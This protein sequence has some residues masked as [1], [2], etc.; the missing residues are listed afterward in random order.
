M[1]LEPGQV[2]KAKVTATPNF[3]LFMAYHG[4]QILVLIPEVSWTASFASC[5]EVAE[6][7]DEFDVMILGQAGVADQYGASIRQLYPENDPWSG[8]WNV[9][10]GDTIEAKV[11]RSVPAADRCNGHRGY[12]LQLRPGVYEMVCE[13]DYGQ[14]QVGRDYVFTVTEV[15]PRGRRIAVSRIE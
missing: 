2:V 14:L 10:P 13:C 8:R 11:I 5:S 12:L 1:P 7:G 9:Q 3:G 4:D 6:V 15:K